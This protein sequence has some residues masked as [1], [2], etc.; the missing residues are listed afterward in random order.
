MGLK[1]GILLYNLHLPTGEGLRAIADMGVPGVHLLAHGE[2][3]PESLDAASRKAAV[4][5]V[6]SYGLEITALQ[7]WGGEEDLGDPTGLDERI[8][9]GM[10][11]LEL[12]SDLGCRIWSAH[13]GVMPFDTA[14]ARWRCFVD[15]LGRL[16]RYAEGI[17]ALMGIETGPEPPFVLRRLIDE[18]GSPA[19]GVNYDPANLI[20]W[21][22]YLKQQAG[23]RY[24]KD[25]AIELY[26]PNEG[27]RLLGPKVFHTHAKDALVQSDGTYLEV[28]L[29]EGWVDWPR[30]VA[31]LQ[32][33][34]YD[35]YFSVER[36]VADDPLGDVRRAV[37]FLK[38]L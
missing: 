14:S 6:K 37:E 21:P 3:A 20:I 22:A 26:Q 25:A 23:G 16:A 30:Y 15:S 28:P 27:P 7:G 4:K 2:W 38:R 8:S 32:A 17:G 18:V 34:G 35:G 11:C 33:Q 31:N 12:A 5:K 13:V 29:G 1:I 24:E 9:Y 10:R 19:L 36:E